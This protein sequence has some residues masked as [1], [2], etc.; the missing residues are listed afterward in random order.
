MEKTCSETT[1]LYG[2]QFDLGKLNAKQLELAKEKIQDSHSSSSRKGDEKLEK[3]GKLPEIKKQTR[4]EASTSR[5]RSFRS[6][7][8]FS[9][10]AIGSRAGLS[11]AVRER[12]H[13]DPKPVEAMTKIAL[14][15]EL[16]L[17]PVHIRAKFALHQQ[18]KDKQKNAK[19]KPAPMPAPSTLQSRKAFKERLRQSLADGLIKMANIHSNLKHKA[20]LLEEK[21]QELCHEMDDLR[22]VA[23]DE[24]ESDIVGVKPHVLARRAELLHRE[25]ESNEK[26]ACAEKELFSSKKLLAE[27]QERKLEFEVVLRDFQDKVDSIIRER[28][29]LEKL[30]EQVVELKK[31]SNAEFASAL[32]SLSFQKE[33]NARGLTEKRIQLNLAREKRMQDEQIDSGLTK[34]EE[35]F[36]HGDPI[37]VKSPISPKLDVHVGTVLAIDFDYDL[38][39]VTVD[40]PHRPAPL[41]SPKGKR[42]KRSSGA[43]EP[44]LL[45]KQ[46]LEKVFNKVLLNARQNKEGFQSALLNGNF[47]EST[48]LSFGERFIAG[49]KKF[50][51]CKKRAE[52]IHR[53]LLE[54][55]HSLSDQRDEMLIQFLKEMKIKEENSMSVEERL[56][57]EIISQVVQNFSKTEE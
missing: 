37:E 57:E 34:W 26:F 46:A 39:S 31:T 41:T 10:E 30:Q 1:L 15:K 12:L 23:G 11:D 44:S 17:V 38:R 19:G 6:A 9:S 48:F 55:L 2:K 50:R 18:K 25:K 5:I 43:F 52:T 33:E 51:K 47:F 53:H 45:W 3:N 54:K 13:F 56:V 49:E 4:P 7:S 29:E 14:R 35:D 40:T 27:E 24:L 42:R 28:I 16:E 21:V 32:S 8:S 20:T 22:A 36:Q